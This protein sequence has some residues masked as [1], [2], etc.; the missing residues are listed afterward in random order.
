MFEASFFAWTICT[1]RIL[2]WLFGAI[3]VFEILLFIVWLIRHG[4]AYRFDLATNFSP[5]KHRT[6]QISLLR[7]IDRKHRF[8]W[9]LF[10][11]IDERFFPPQMPLNLLWQL[12][13]RANVFV[14]KVVHR[15]PVIVLALASLLAFFP[16]PQLSYVDG[17]IVL[18]VI[19]SELADL[20]L[21]RAI[22]GFWD[23]FR[24]DFTFTVFAH[25]NDAA[26]ILPISRVHFCRSSC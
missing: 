9:P 15:A 26:G 3:K 21:A 17:I 2:V 16:H 23:N 18:A 4:N 1:F 7:D 10:W 5:T 22:L 11:R 13:K 8:P 14:A 20:L 6:Y 19:F 12:S 24:L 25:V